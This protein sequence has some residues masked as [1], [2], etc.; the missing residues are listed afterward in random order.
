L[1]VSSIYVYCRY[2]AVKFYLMRLDYVFEVSDLR[3]RFSNH[4]Y[5]DCCILMRYYIWYWLSLRNFMKTRLCIFWKNVD[6]ASKLINLFNYWHDYCAWGLGCYT[7]NFGFT[8]GNNIWWLGSTWL[9]ECGLHLIGWFTWFVDA[10]GSLSKVI[11]FSLWDK[12]SNL[13]PLVSYVNKQ[14]KISHNFRYKQ[15]FTTTKNFS[16]NLK[17]KQKFIII[18]TFN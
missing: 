6:V 2:S 16:H 3:L 8:R 13:L 18:I 11:D 1:T 12:Q 9:E 14:T 17:Y 7:C 15:K 5:E 10:W 4:G